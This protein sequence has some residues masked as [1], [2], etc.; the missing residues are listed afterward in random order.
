MLTNI[1]ECP[2]D[3]V[4]IDQCVEAVFDE[5]TPDVTLVKFRPIGAH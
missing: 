2:P 5:V 3:Q 1:V 4:K